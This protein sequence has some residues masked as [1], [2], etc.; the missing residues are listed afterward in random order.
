MGRTLRG[1]W[2]PQPVI[3]GLGERSGGVG[4]ERPGDRTRADLCLPG[5]GA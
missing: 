2:L 3:G 4:G 5:P 1:V